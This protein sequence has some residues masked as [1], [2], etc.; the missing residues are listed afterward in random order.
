VDLC[1]FKASVDSIES[2]RQS[3]LQREP[4]SKQKKDYASKL[5][6]KNAKI[7]GYCLAFWQ[8]GA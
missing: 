3:G 2:P 4:V 8:T 7:K 6:F 1:E 5:K